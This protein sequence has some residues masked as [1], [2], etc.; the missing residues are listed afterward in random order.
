MTV[1]TSS[2]EDLWDVIATVTADVMNTGSLGG[3]EIAQLYV[4]IPG[5]GQP[6]KQLRGFSK[7][8]ISPGQTTTVEF[9]LM[10]RDLSIWD[11]ATQQWHLQSGNYKIYVGASSRILPLTGTLSIGE[12]RVGT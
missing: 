2:Q 6:P 8:A 3:T 12:R 10:R 1:L 9:D 7:V 5:A 4:A 11:V